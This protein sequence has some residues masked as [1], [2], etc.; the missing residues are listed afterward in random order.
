MK[1]I[2]LTRGLSAMV[3]DEDFTFLS[4]WKWYATAKHGQTHYAARSEHHYKNGIDKVTHIKMHRVILNVPLGMETDHIDGNGLNNQKS[5]LRIVTNRENHHNIHVT[6]TNGTL[7]G[8]CYDTRRKKWGSKIII[9]G[10][11]KSLGYWNTEGE[12]HLQYMKE[13][14]RLKEI[15]TMGGI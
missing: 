6:R 4:Q 8:A 2:P 13:A 10:K 12:A 15:E 11:T 1:R 7:L 14:T 9:G 3:D 5:N